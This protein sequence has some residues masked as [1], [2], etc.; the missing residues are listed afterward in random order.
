MGNHIFSDDISP[1]KNN[2]GRRHSCPA[3]KKLLIQ[4]PL[5][6]KKNTVHIN[7]KCIPGNMAGR[8]T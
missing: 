2:S 1:E 4:S 3:E 8:F 6:L 5:I 7:I